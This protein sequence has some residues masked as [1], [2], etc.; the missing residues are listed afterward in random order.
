MKKFFGLAFLL[1]LLFC[2]SAS[3]SAQVPE[4]LRINMDVAKELMRAGKPEEAVKIIGQLIDV[5][6]ESKEL[7]ELLKDALLSLKEYDRVEQMIKED[8]SHA[9]NDWQLYTQLANVYLKTR[10]MDEAKDN[11][12]R[13]ISLVPDKKFTY[14]EVANV[15]LR[16]GLRSEAMD[17]YKLARMKMGVP[18]VFALELAGLYEQLF[19]Y[20]QAVDEYFLFMAEDST[21]FDLVEDRINRLIQTD[22]HLDQIELALNQRIRKD[23]RDRYSHKLI[24]DLLFRRNDLDGAFESYKTVDEISK[25]N[26]R[27]I[28]RFVQ[29]C[30]NQ[31]LYDQA[32]KS[33]QYILSVQSPAEVAVAAELYIAR[34]YEGQEKFADATAAY[35]GIIDKYRAHFT[36]EI[37][38]SYF[39]IGEIN[40]F[41][42]R[43]PDDAFPRYQYVVSRFQGS[44]LYPAALVRRGDCMMAKGNL[45][46]AR[47]LLTK[48]AADHLAEPKMEEI[49]FKLTEIDFFQGNFES[50]LQGYNRVIAD[51]PKGFYVNNSLE[52]IILIGEHQDLDRPLLVSFADA[53]LEK[54]QGNTE[55]ALSKLDQLISAKS[56]KLSDLAQME[57]AK[58]YRDEKEYS[59]SLKSL[60]KLLEEYPESFLCP[61]AQMMIGDLYNYHLDEK[62]KAIEAYQ[63][64]LKDYERSVYVDEVRDRLRELKADV[65]PSSSG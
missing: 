42:F 14:Q 44:R 33:S 38:Y 32:V 18:N 52:R 55:S 30:L 59:R 15:Y 17:T 65:S 1:M 53:L 63:K 8:L 57:K 54:T 12:N 20:K 19:D 2:F 37:A 7:R 11:M 16:N 9:P 10:R 5:Y 25:A 13:A 61:Q 21:K 22:E 40:L 3:V 56:A 26:G 6:G 58:I 45:D 46:S 36:Q 49:L 50:A 35:Q 29:M 4:K 28:L 64:L 51:F 24:G 60:E 31:N 23:K 34:S 41:Q 39:K 47:T 48:A 27:Y 62:T 43:K